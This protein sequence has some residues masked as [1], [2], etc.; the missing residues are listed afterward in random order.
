MSVTLNAREIH[1]L[2]KEKKAFARSKKQ[3]VASWCEN[4]K[5]V[6]GKDPSSSDK[7][8]IK[9]MIDEYNAVKREYDELKA[10][11]C[12]QALLGWKKGSGKKLNSLNLKGSTWGIVSTGGLSSFP[13]SPQLAFGYPSHSAEYNRTVENAVKPASNVAPDEAARV[14]LNAVTAGCTGAEN[15]APGDGIDDEHPE[16]NE[17]AAL[18]PTGFQAQGSRGDPAAPDAEKNNDSSLGSICE[19]AEAGKVE[20]QYNL[21]VL[22]FS[23]GQGVEKDEAQAAEWL[24]KAAQQGDSPA[25]CLLGYMYEHG[26][27]VAQ[28]DK[29]A[30]QWTRAAAEK[31]SP[32]AQFNLTLMEPRSRAR[33]ESPL[34]EPPTPNQEEALS[35]GALGDRGDAADEVEAR[36]ESGVRLM[37]GSESAAPDPPGA[38]QLFLEAGKA[39]N[40]DSQCILGYMY[41]RGLGV[42]PNLGEAVRWT[43]AAAELGSGEAMFNLG[44]LYQRGHGVAKDESAAL[45]LFREASEL[46]LPEAK[47]NFEYLRIALKPGA[48]SRAE[49]AVLMYLATGEVPT[50]ADVDYVV[51]KCGKP[52]SNVGK[53]K[54]ADEGIIQR[55]EAG[56]IVALWKGILEARSKGGDPVKQFSLAQKAQ[57]KGACVVS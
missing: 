39:G 1:G 24:L 28:S 34:G 44:V 19:K 20:A 57:K 16:T 32:E 27:G 6:N 35:H 26:R 38:L 3:E 30:L 7:R 11:Q 8:E 40:L 14:T 5:K 45:R 4:F 31:G 47:A 50:D 36:Y 33:E 46:G 21:G 23:G 9:G 37:H 12:K 42:T 48:V 51:F 43:K 55:S 25:M 17:E 18:A 53:R 56:A 15:H 2:I 54:V 22:Y 13:E 10:Q 49:L 52:D 29:E 41:E